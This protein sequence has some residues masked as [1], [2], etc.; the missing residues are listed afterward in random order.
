M[1]AHY[2]VVCYILYCFGNIYIIVITLCVTLMVFCLFV[3]STALFYARLLASVHRKT[4]FDEFEVIMWL[5]V[6]P[7]VLLW[8]LSVYF[9]V[10]RTV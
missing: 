6:L 3:G 7:L 10:Q 4:D 8:W 1:Y 2:G 5:S 9:T